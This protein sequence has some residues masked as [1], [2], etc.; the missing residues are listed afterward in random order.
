M[1]IEGVMGRNL[2][3]RLDTQAKREAFEKVFLIV[4]EQEGEAVARAW[5]VGMVPTLG[6]QN[7]FLLIVEGKGDEVAEAARAYIDG[8][9]D[10]I[11][12]LKESPF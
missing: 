4:S 3:D 1:D 11:D 8:D 6:N 12:W 2:A 10:H 9:A 5:M 7:P